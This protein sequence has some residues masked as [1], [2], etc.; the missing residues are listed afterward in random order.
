MGN[1]AS[2]VS[3]LHAYELLLMYGMKS[4]RYFIQSTLDGDKGNSRS[5]GELSQSPEFQCF[6][7]DIKAKLD[8]VSQTDATSTA[9]QSHPK[10]QELVNILLDHFKE[11]GN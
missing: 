7:N 6:W 11:K 3:L 2:A 10:L 8:T 4:F 9:L 1:F 5:K